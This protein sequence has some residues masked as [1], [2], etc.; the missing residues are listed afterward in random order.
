MKARDTAKGLGGCDPAGPESHR[1]PPLC[2]SSACVVHQVF[3]LCGASGI[4]AAFPEGFFILRV[5]QGTWWYV[6]Q[7]VWQSQGFSTNANLKLAQNDPHPDP[8]H[9][10]AALR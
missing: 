10:V 7:P 6:D 8:D 4:H 3:V 1:C 2:Q 9:P 5:K